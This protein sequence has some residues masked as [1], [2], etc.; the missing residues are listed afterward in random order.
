MK[1]IRKKL[2]NPLIE[3]PGTRPCIKIMQRYLKE[4][5]FVWANNI[6]LSLS[7]SALF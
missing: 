2:R 6:K 3:V 4:L 7:L 5:N 1:Y